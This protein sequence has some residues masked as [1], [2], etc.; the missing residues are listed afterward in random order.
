MS[1]VGAS[2]LVQ[3]KRHYPGQHKEQHSK[4]SSKD[5]DESLEKGIDADAPLSAEQ[6]SVNAKEKNVK[7]GH[8]DEYA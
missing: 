3:E 6:K 8:I 5:D 2:R 7:L 1:P 4:Q